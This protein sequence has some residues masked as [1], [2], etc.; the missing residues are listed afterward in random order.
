M[1]FLRKLSIF[2][3]SFLLIHSQNLY[4]QNLDDFQLPNYNIDSREMKFALEFSNIM[5]RVSEEV[6]ED[7]ADFRKALSQAQ[8]NPEALE[9]IK[10]GFLLYARE[11]EKFFSLDLDKS[12]KFQAFWKRINIVK[13]AQLME[14]SLIGMKVFFK[15]RG[16]SV[17]LAVAMGIV[18]EWLVPVILVN[19]GLSVLLPIS[20]I[21]PWSTM[22]LS[23][24]NVV[25]K[26]LIKRK[27]TADL[28][29]K[30]QYKAY[31]AQLHASYDVL[32]LTNPDQLILPLANEG[33]IV[34]ALVIPKQTTWNSLLT[35]IGLHPKRL[36]YQ[37]LRLFIAEHGLKSNYVDWI[38]KNPK[39][40]KSV[41]I[42]LLVN[43]ILKN[44]D[45]D[46]TAHF[47]TKFSNHFV[48]VQNNANWGAVKKWAK[49]MIK[50]PTTRDAYF[51]AR[52]VPE[53]TSVN[54]VLQ[55][56]QKMY[57][58]E[59]VTRLPI[60]Y[61]QYR[62]IDDALEMMRAKSITMDNPIWDSQW[63]DEFL[64]KVISPL[65]KPLN[66]CNS[67]EASLLKYLIFN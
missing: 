16:F 11:Y 39:F 25:N 44:D 23:I 43:H 65:S 19:I 22:Y 60:G 35:K 37:S 20:M 5:M 9:P 54:E 56:W 40:D 51:R 15:K 38:S 48:T 8:T 33:N 63:Q 42:Y 6:F 67:K 14:K 1:D 49:E 50:A 57:M 53:G 52:N 13:I 32:K 24:P 55:L 61:Q 10:K 30:Q 2:I 3:C 27:I 7:E 41:K 31:M 36:N 26:A 4:A 59:Y 17:A 46:I 29:G 66:S 34:D 58:P 12:V 47:K 62:K 28:G 64:E 21:T 45:P 18:S